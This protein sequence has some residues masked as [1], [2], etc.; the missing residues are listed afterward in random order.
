MTDT[1]ADRTD[2][3]FAEP[4]LVD[5]IEL[6]TV[7]LPLRE[8]FETSFG[9][10]TARPTILVRVTANGSVGWGEVAALEAPLYTG[11]TLGTARH[12]IRDF[13]A[14]A[15]LAGP[16]ARL[17]EVA[18]A[19]AP[20]R[21]HQ[22]AKAGLELALV[23]LAGRL[24]GASVSTLLGGTREAVAVGVSL[25]LPPSVGALVDTVARHLAIGYRRIKLKIKPG[26]DIDLVAAVRARFPD[27]L[28]S[29][30]ANAAYTLADLERLR[31]LD[32]YRLLMIEQP[33]DP[34]DLVDHAALQRELRTPICL[35]E[36]IGRPRHAEQAIAL[37]SCRIINIKVGRVGGYR[38]ALAIHACCRRH[39]VPVWCGGMLESGIGRA[40]NLALASLPGFTLPG[41]ISASVRYYDRDVL[42]RPIE[43]GPGGTIAVPS[44]AGIGVDPGEDYVDAL[45]ESLERLD[46]AAGVQPSCA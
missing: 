33:L 46:R 9:R 30:D 45:T 11:E 22:M 7:R 44:G 5:R 28:L 17:S 40:H 20:I 1:Q 37:G 34:D 31:R 15:L 3:R 38:A 8:P 35:D 27:I 25:G 2:V 39:G 18:Q 32:A 4:L 10:V 13:L 6:R 42:I 43:L 21:G 24:Q 23:D 29:V 12:V 16:F 41:D 14:P 26:R 36:S 19:L